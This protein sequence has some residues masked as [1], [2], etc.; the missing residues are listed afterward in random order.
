MKRREFV[1]NITLATAGLTT[2]GKMNALHGSYL[3]ADIEITDSFSLNGFADEKEEYPNLIS[4]GKG[5]NWLFSLRRLPYPQ[6]AEVIAGYKMKGGEWTDFGTASLQPGQ[7]ENPTAVCLPGKEPVVAWNRI[8]EG[9]WDIQ[10]THFSDNNPQL[11]L[12]FNSRNGQAVNPKLFTG[13]KDTIWLVWEN[14]FQR[15]IAVFAAYFKNGRWSD[16]VRM[17]PVESVC[18][19]PA[20]AEGKDGKLYLAYGT[21]EG[22]HQNIEMLVFD[23]A[24]LKRE[25]LVP[26]AIGGGLENRVNL[27]TKPAIAFDRKNRLWISWENNRNTHRFDDGD[28]YTGDRCC[29]MVCYADG[30]IMEPESGKWLF[31]GGNDHLPVFNK[32]ANGDLFVFTRCGGDFKKSNNWKFRYSKL[33]Y[34][35]WTEPKVFLNTDQKGQTSVPAV[36]FEDSNIFWLGWRNEKLKPSEA[37][38]R[39]K[40]DRIELS[41]FKVSDY[42]EK[43][44]EIKLVSSVVEEHH[45]AEIKTRIGGRHRVARRKM[46]YRGEEYTLILGDLHEHTEGSYCWPAGADGTLHEEYRYGLYSEGYDFVGIT[47]HTNAM[48]E[49][50]WR[51]N[52]RIADLYNEDGF[53]IAIPAAEWTL[54]PERGYDTIPIGVGHR[55]VIFSSTSEARKFIRN[56]NEIYSEFSPECNSSPKLWSLIRKKNIDCVAIPHHVTSG[57]H[58][59]S[60]EVRDEEIEPVVELFQCRGNAEYR[61]CPRENNV[62]RHHTTHRDE[63]FVDYA[64]REK[65][66]HIG[67]IGSGEHNNMGVG[68]AALWV[69]EVS[70]KGILEALR[71]RRCF[72][73]TGDKIFIDFKVNEALMGE[74][75]KTHTSPV[76]QIKTQGQKTIAK[77]ELLRNS[78]VIKSWEPENGDETLFVTYVDENYQMEQKVLYYYV[79]V[80]QNDEHL[81]WSSPVFIDLS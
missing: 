42:H 81:A 23:A 61:G 22:F 54:S 24:S 9:K 71:A 79:R 77:I 48:D 55:N 39:V 30:K 32:N 75:I 47:D 69:K 10:L 80:T 41:R 27:N 37:G 6:N 59:C 26:V 13:E 31:N 56:T 15:K 14:Y 53:F 76:I 40:E 4:N 36:V 7:Y 17:T 20:L 60:W 50:Y 67:F 74:R 19:D 73:T 49:P 58:P 12:H 2:A 65:G 62:D 68:L 38:N 45:P 16:P 35:G 43:L 11:P 25:M 46:V 52:L 18:F 34:E 29:S 63:A 5:E 70:R 51:K 44:G 28:N 33:G 72:G 3:P 57:S 1:R 66:Y 64:L 21:K 78:R 8:I